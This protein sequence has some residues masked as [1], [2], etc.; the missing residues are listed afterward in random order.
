M[1]LFAKLSSLIER[2]RRESQTAY[3]LS[4]LSDRDLSDLGISRIDIKRLA[5]ESAE[6]G[7]IDLYDWRDRRDAVATGLAA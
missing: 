6:N 1:A 3:E 5:R 2:R 7:V 4:L